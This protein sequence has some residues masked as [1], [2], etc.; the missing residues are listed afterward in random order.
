MISNIS[1]SYEKRLREITKR[2]VTYLKNCEKKVGG[3][4]TDRKTTENNDIQK[5]FQTIHHEKFVEHVKM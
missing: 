3:D 4:I 5:I 2:F 1:D